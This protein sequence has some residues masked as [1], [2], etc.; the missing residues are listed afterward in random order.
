MS[1]LYRPIS[2]FYKQ[3]FGHK[4]YKIPV[5][6]TYDC[7]NRRGLKGMETCVFCDPW[8]SAAN[9]N[10]LEQNLATQIEEGL[11]RLRQKYKA[12]KFLVYFQAYTN[13][14]TKILELRENFDTALRYPDVVGV[15][16]GTRPDCLSPALFE[17]WSEYAQKTYVGIE[18]GVQSFN[19]KVLQFMKRGHTRRQSLQA[20]EKIKKHTPCDVGIHLIFGSPDEEDRDLVEAAHLAHE[21]GIHNVKLHNLHVLKGTALETMYL[22]G[23]FNPIDFDEYAR[24]VR[25]FLE[26]LSPEIYVHRL[27]ALSSRPEELLAPAWTALKM[28]THQDI[29]EH[30][31]AHGSFQGRHHHHCQVKS[32][33]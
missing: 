2:E 3:R 17:L 13:T 7:P 24:R 15:V 16:I 8:G 14:F 22:S 23:R 19:D 1:A 20:I 32:S 30:L 12:E 11:V 25:V 26:H 5:A 18:L 10:L 31:K 29:L 21:M 4:V 33:S 28:K 9:K 6:V 27:A